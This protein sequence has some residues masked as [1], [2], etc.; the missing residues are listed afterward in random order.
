MEKADGQH[1]P[2]NMCVLLGPLP[3]DLLEESEQS[4]PGE[5]RKLGHFLGV[6]FF[7]FFFFKWLHPWHME[8]PRIG[9][10]SEPQLLAYTPATAMPD[11]SHKC[12]LH[13]G[14]QQHG[15]LNILSEARDRTC[16][17]TDTMSGS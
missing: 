1:C 2:S 13:L 15:I 8:V 14:S 17:L 12:D 3:P 9:V 11:P 10:K 4:A 7:F 16:I 6:L 5:C